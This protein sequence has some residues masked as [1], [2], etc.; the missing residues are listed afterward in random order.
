MAGVKMTL[1]AM[2][3]GLLVLLVVFSAAVGASAVP[4]TPTDLVAD[5]TGPG[6]LK[7][8]DNRVAVA[9]EAPAGNPLWAIP[10]KA[11]S[12]TRERPIFSPSRRPPA[13][14]VAA[15]PYA[16]P[17]QPAKPAEPDRPQLSLVGT[18]AGDT[19]GF[20]IFLDRSA[21]TVLRL[22]TGEAH[23]GWILR[24]VR[25]RETVLEKGDR[26]VTLALPVR[27]T[28]SFGRS[29]DDASGLNPLTR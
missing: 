11:L 6:L 3:R 17:P 20:G 5:D 21:N 27:A 13:P 14:A 29:A 15:A 23:K 9:N 24:E 16:P 4:T 1:S 10:I 2:L 18:I 26:T 12:A 8:G 22:K 19:E 7:F 28:A 25:G